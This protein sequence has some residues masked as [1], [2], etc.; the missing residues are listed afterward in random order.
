M[1]LGD[2]ECWIEARPGR[3]A[4]FTVR[5][6]IDY[7]TQGGIGR[8]T[9]QMSINPTSFRQD[10]CRLARSC[11]K[12]K[13]IGCWRRAWGRRATPADL[14]VFDSTG[15]IDSNDCFRDEV[16]SPQSARFGLGDFALAGCDVIGHVVAHRSGH[17]LNAD[18]V[19][20]LRTREKR[21]PIAGKVLR[22]M[23][24]YI[25]PNVSIDPAPKLATMCTL[26]HSA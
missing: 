16:R 1:R 25:A 7:G 22:R 3:T 17:R 15:P 26:V 20:V 8:Q 9:V 10:L 13:P 2:D 21:S 11:S 19:R 4:E 14:L 6:R 18:M 5:Y 12:R 23:A 24:T